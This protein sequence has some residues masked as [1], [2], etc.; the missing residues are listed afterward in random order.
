[1]LSGDFI[2]SGL[3]GVLGLVALGGYLN[4]IAPND[5]HDGDILIPMV[6]SLTS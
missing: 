5:V 1:V 4:E 6:S 3:M 2:P